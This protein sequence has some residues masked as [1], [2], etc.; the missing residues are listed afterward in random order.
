MSGAAHL[1]PGV[2]FAG[3]V[4]DAQ[5]AELY[6]GAAVVCVP[7]RAEGF[8]LPLLEAMAAGAPV[9]ASDLPALREVGG[10]AVRFVP[11]GDAGA[12]ATEVQAVLADDRLRAVMVAAGRA[13]AA[14][15]RWSNVALATIAA[16]E[17]ALGASSSP[18]R[19]R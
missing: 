16:Y 19:S 7:S 12:L 18:G 13:R 15:Y 6:R 11:P 5:L 14:T 9:V 2:R 4:T 1:A 3:H 10:D 8:G 17:R